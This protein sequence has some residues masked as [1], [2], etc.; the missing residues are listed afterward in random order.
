MEDEKFITSF[1]I[2]IG[3]DAFRMHPP[4][5]RFS[6]NERFC[7]ARLE[8]MKDWFNTI[9]DSQ[10]DQNLKAIEAKR[11]LDTFFA[12]LLHP[13]IDYTFHV[14]TAKEENKDSQ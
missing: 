8:D 1:S 5:I 13:F 12:D 3:Q 2:D 9:W 11:N 6:I 4:M 10:G 14:R 7:V